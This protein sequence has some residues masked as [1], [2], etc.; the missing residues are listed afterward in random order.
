MRSPFNWITLLVT[1]L[2]AAIF[3]V[4]ILPDSVQ[5]YRP[6]WLALVLIYWVLRYPEKIGM[7]CA[8]FFGLVMDVI[9]GKP[10]GVHV[11]AFSVSTYLI[12]SMHQRL[13]LFPIVQ[14]SVVLF[15]LVAIQLMIVS[16]L[17][18]FLMNSSSNLGFMWYALTSAIIWPVI[19]ILTDRVS[20]AMR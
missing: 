4:M 1:F 14:Q 2:I 19:I 17:S 5:N 13:K 7:T 9:S 6:Q 18:K 15:F 12:L 3:E 16:L 11:L 8:L 10:F 20:V